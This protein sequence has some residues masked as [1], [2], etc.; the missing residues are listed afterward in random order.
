[1]DPYDIIYDALLT[2]M[3]ITEDA[4][5]DMADP[6]S[7]AKHD[8]ARHGGHFD[9]E[10]QT[11]KLRE[12]M[13]LPTAKNNVKQDEQ[14]DFSEMQIDDMLGESPDKSEEEKDLEDKRDNITAEGKEVEVDIDKDEV[15]EPEIETEEDRELKA[16]AET[17][18]SYLL[19]TE[20]ECR[21][22]EDF[23]DVGMSDSGDI[24]LSV[25]DIARMTYE[26]NGRDVSL[27]TFADTFQTLIKQGDTKM[28]DVDRIATEYIKGVKEHPEMFVPQLD[29]AKMSHMRY[30]FTGK[31]ELYDPENLQHIG[32]ENDIP[33][34]VYNLYK[35]ALGEEKFARMRELLSNWKG[36]TK[37]EK[38]ELQGLEAEA[39]STDT[40]QQAL[41]E[42]AEKVNEER[43]GKVK[44]L[45]QYF[46]DNDDYTDAEKAVILNGAMRYGISER[47]VNGG[48][49]VRLVSLSDNNEAKV[50]VI[51]GEMTAK[52]VE[53]LRNGEPYKKA[54]VGA[55]QEMRTLSA[56]KRGVPPGFEGWKVYKKDPSQE[57]AVELNQAV[58]GTGWCT[59]GAVSTAQMHR[60]GGDFHVYFRNGEPLIAIRTTDGRMAEPPRG[61]HDGQFCTE[62]EE[63]IA[64]EYIRGNNGI[65]AGDAYLKDRDDI[66]KV[67]SGKMTWQDAWR[68]PAERRY[69]NGEYGGDTKAWPKPMLDAIE[70][71]KAE[72]EEERKASGWFTDD[73]LESMPDRSNVVAII[74]EDKNDHVSIEGDMPNLQ[75]VIGGAGADIGEGASVPALTSIDG[76]A[77]IREGASVPNLKTV[78]G[79]PY[80]GQ[81][82]RMLKTPSGKV[83]GT[84]DRATNKVTLYKG[85][86]VDTLVHELG[87]HA[88]MQFAQQCAKAGNNTLINKINESIDNAPEN[89]W[90]SVR[91]R[92]QKAKNESEKDYNERLRDEVWAAVVEGKSKEVE[93][94]RKTAKGERWYRRAWNTIKAC[95]AGVLG[96]MGVKVPWGSDNVNGMNP[97]KF[98]EFIV[99]AVKE[100]RNLGSIKPGKDSGLRQ[101]AIKQD[102]YEQWNKILD[103][104][105]KGHVS[106]HTRLTVLKE[107]PIVLQ[108]VGANNLPIHISGGVLQKIVGEIETKTGDRHGV[109]I[110]ELRGLQIELDNP[111]AVFDSATQPD[112][113]VVLTRMVDAQNNERAVV[114]LRL[115]REASGNHTVNDI[116]S[117]YGKSKNSVINW[118]KTS[119]LRYVNKR[120]RRES[121]RWLQ[122]PGDSTLRARK[123][124]TEEDF[125]GDELGRIVPNNAED[126][127]SPRS[128]VVQ[129]AIGQDSAE[130]RMVEFRELM[131]KKFPD[132]D[133]TAI[134]SELGKIGSAEE[135]EAY[136]RRILK[137][138]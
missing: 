88:T 93:D 37:E 133:A 89:V 30:L 6:D 92:Y 70:K 15:Q 76:D 32:V 112:S 108:R 26:M 73:E 107:T 64:D 34:Q 31:G 138:G 65:V 119:L 48:L 27:K 128:S 62:E 19:G 126:V 58:A 84:Y 25:K 121:A 21:L 77:N 81:S 124:M 12:D 56:E 100:G 47:R 94:A 104:F 53:R 24:R 50:P 1:M 41:A 90:E 55:V 35:D 69:E 59:G 8:K 72:N 10:T 79:K 13:G 28:E 9:P 86:T 106:P 20:V 109:P 134:I 103:E 96:R 111:I 18:K 38:S 33:R 97:S 61:A 95:F 115:D 39:N 105:E 132:K 36:L 78:A 75:E 74:A 136:L 87:G 5:P 130:H 57:A 14:T 120:A 46:E 113:L 102:E 40:M 68:M 135:Q 49:E 66:K 129:M 67:Q 42:N 125:Q 99:N 29:P 71:I 82:V 2:S 63:D 16:Y 52:I 45:I 127:K 22:T 44:E 83:V 131:A 91:S 4:E 116:A 123:V 7:W 54:I 122:L 60:S 110:S 137:G 17:A 80:N 114:A 101:M 98:K 3:G 51:G 117:I 118:A 11:C 85:S 23:D 43:I